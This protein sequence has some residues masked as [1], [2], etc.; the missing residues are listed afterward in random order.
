MKVIFAGGGTGGHLY[1][2][3]AMARAMQKRDPATKILFVGTDEGIEARIL[4]EEGLELKTLRVMGLKGK[5]RME[6]LKALL[7]LPRALLDSF[8][9]LRSFR[10][11]AVV[12][13]GGYASGP[14]ILAGVLSGRTVVLQEQNSIP[15]FTNRI[16]G[17][18]ADRV[19]TAYLE[20]HA[21]FPRG[22]V[23]QTGNPVR[24]GLGTGSR[25]D[26][27]TQFGLD[28]GKKTIF[29]LGGSR[30]AHVLNQV[31]SDMVR[32]QSF[33]DI[34]V[35]FLHQTGEADL[36][37]VLDA[38]TSSGIKAEVRS[39]FKEM[40]QAYAAADLAISRSGAVAL[41]ELCAAGIP[42]IL[43]PFPYAADDHQ[44]RNARVTAG[45]GAAE[46]L[47]QND[48]TPATLEARIRVLLNDPNR[49]SEM[50]EAARRHALPD[51]ART[52]VEDLEKRVKAA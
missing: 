21:Y 41:S 34:P 52:V 4:P 19:Y 9:I 8:S 5:K 46:V 50:R 32:K 48:L 18:L 27:L 43:V 16:L 26:A 39:Y 44:M 42:Q 30:G 22:K 35:Q 11:D 17:R 37:S 24:E 3:I 1:P 38:Y 2:A 25:E 14:L 7:A 40:I 6:Q 31:V 15:G 20:S 28:P 29:V 36:K 47:V 33:S 49:L 45:T 13:V 51:A 12:G 23:L 10:P